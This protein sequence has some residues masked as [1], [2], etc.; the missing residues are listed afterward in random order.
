MFLSADTMRLLIDLNIPGDKLLE[1]YASMERDFR[2][3]QAA[4][5][6]PKSVPSQARRDANARYYQA[7]KARPKISESTESRL[8]KTSEFGLKPTESVLIKTPLARV[9][10]KPL[11]IIITDTSEANASSVGRTSN[12]LT[13]ESVSPKPTNGRR[14]PD[15]WMPSRTTLSQFTAKGYSTDVIDRELTSFRDYWAAESGQRARKHDWDAAFRTWIARSFNGKRGGQGSCMAAGSGNAAG[16]NGGDVS[17]ADLF[18][19]RY[20]GSAA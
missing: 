16:R 11:R 3:V 17:F 6:P 13:L 9:E 5:L 7:K 20:G 19:Q 1:I 15:G 18:V 10:D 4:S 8:I 14:L 12:D 2:L